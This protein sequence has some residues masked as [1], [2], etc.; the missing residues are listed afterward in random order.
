MNDLLKTGIAYWLAPALVSGVA[1]ALAML[2][3]LTFTL[4]VAAGAITCVIVAVVTLIAPLA[5]ALR[6]WGR[7]RFSPV[8]RRHPRP[9]VW[10]QWR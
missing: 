8:R 1:V 2:F 9:I 5:G 7:N 3:G 6:R 4:I 10:N